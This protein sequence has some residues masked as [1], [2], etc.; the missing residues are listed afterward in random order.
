VLR[1][2]RLRGQA[3][4]AELALH[5]VREAHREGPNRFLQHGRHEGEEARGVDPAGKEETERHVAHE[6]AAHGIGQAAAQRKRS[7][8][9]AAGGGGGGRGRELP[10]A[11]LHESLPDLPGERPSG[12]ELA[13]AAEEGRFAGDE[14]GGE[15]LRQHVA[16]ELGLAPGGQDGLDLGG[17][18]QLPLGHGVEERL[19]AEPVAGEQE[20]LAGAVPDGEGEHPLQPLDAALAFLFVEMEDRLRVAAAPVVV[21][22]GLQSRAQRGVVVDLPVEDD[23]HRAVFVRHRLMAAGHVHDGQPPMGQARRAVEPA[24]FAVGTTMAQDVAHPHEARLLHA[25]S[26]VQLDDS[27]DATHGC[28]GLRSRSVR[29]GRWRP[30]RIPGPSG[31]ARRGRGPAARPRRRR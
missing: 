24:A 12:Q 13:H 18:D 1:S 3:R 22:E 11:P 10:V 31:P 5:V 25:L 19:D 20:A 2:R 27:G 26:R 21:A 17:E 16:V 15:I 28:P 29:V 23:P 6:V 9:H 4:V 8:P 30:G 14:A 7:L